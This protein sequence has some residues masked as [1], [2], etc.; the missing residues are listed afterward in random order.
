MSTEG[1]VRAGSMSVGGLVPQL[2]GAC[3]IV[4]AGSYLAQPLTARIA[5][6]LHLAPNLA[7]LIVTLS[8]IGYCLGLLF[9][10]PLADRFENRRLL[11]I[12]LAAS[13]ASML[14]AAFSPAGV[15]F[16]VAAAGIGVSSVAVQLIVAQAA[17]L[18]D[19]ASRGRVV[20]GVTSGLLWGILAAWPV[21][22]LLGDALG[23]RALFLLEAAAVL[24]LVPWLRSV[25]PEWQP[26]TRMAYLEIAA[27]LPWYWR[28]Y[29]EL[30]MRAAI[31]SLLFGVFSMTWT[32]LPVWLRDRYGF[33][34]TAIACFGLAGAAGALVVP[35][36]G[37]LADRGRTSVT[38]IVAAAAVAASGLVMCFDPPWWM[39]L[40][41]VIGI[42]G[43][44]QASHVVSQRRVLALEPRAANR[45]NSLYV[46]GFFLGGAAGSALAMPLYRGHAAW[47]GIAG[48]L[49]GSLALV[50]A[51][52]LRSS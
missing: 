34:A 6:D 46:G 25:L 45:L 7:G 20:G 16:L 5:A 21:A 32:S 52:S 27:S 18:C 50:L 37:R 42:S 8:Q 14:L 47:V 36:A 41:S 30:R 33:H 4:A 3:G 10:S 31:Q 19:D 48:M 43:G 17:R 49:A 39:L 29:G 13:A 28:R 40:I 24:I 51:K 38:S 35:L 44:V 22:N 26:Q 12:V 23:W 15:W 9:V 2:A 1:R 11:T